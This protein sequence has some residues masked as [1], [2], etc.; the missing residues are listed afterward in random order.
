LPEDDADQYIYRS[1]GQKQ[2]LAVLSPLQGID[3]GM[4]SSSSD[5]RSC[6]YCYVFHLAHN[7]KKEEGISVSAASEGKTVI[8]YCAI[9][10][11]K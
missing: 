3:G 7:K 2:Q 1:L 4:G 6:I 11:N 9:R 10:T 8:D 5:A